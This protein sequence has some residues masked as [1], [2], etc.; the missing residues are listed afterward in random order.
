M[1]LSG[2]V[3]LVGYATRI[4]HTGYV[5]LYHSGHWLPVFDSDWTLD[6]GV[7][8][9][10]QLGYITAANILPP[11]F[12]CP[13]GVSGGRVVDNVTCSGGERSLAQCQYNTATGTLS[14]NASGVVCAS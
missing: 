12:Y 10:R 7:A 4:P 3:R 11:D 2:A 14:R 6:E 8:V 9:C 13:N 5:E 1:L